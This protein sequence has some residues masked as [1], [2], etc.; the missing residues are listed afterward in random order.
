M[1]SAAFVDD[2]AARSRAARAPE[3]RARSCARAVA[4]RGRPRRPARPRRHPRRHLRRSSESP[5]GYRRLGVSLPRDLA[6]RGRRRCARPTPRSPPNCNARSPTNCRRIAATAASC[7][8][9]TSRRST[10]RARCATNRAASSP[11]LQ[12]RY[13]ETTGI[14]SLKI[15]HNNV[16]GYFVDVTA[17]HGDKLM[18]RA[19]QRDLHPSPDH[20]PARCASPPPSSASWKPRSPAPPTARWRSSS[21][22]STGSPPR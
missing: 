21:R 1:R 5:S 10:R 8:R 9:A 6:R 17:Q 16:L 19:A 15:R 4:H 7:A 12:V 2:G 3:S 18:S 13:A 22:S 20:S 11:R 14:R